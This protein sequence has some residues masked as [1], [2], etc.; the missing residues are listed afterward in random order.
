MSKEV[1]MGERLVIERICSGDELALKSLYQEHFPMILRFVL[2]NNGSSDEAKD[3]YQEAVII[4]YENIRK[5]QFELTCKIS[6]YLY[7]VCRRL[8]LKQL[9]LKS[10]N[11]S[12]MNDNDLFVEVDNDV[13][14]HDEKEQKIQL[15]RRCMDELG[16]PCKTILTDFFFVQ[17]TME[18]IANKMGYTNAANAKN[19]K[20]KCFNRFKKLVIVQ[21]R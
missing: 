13:D 4:F 14:D 8:W 19:Q 12:E 10:R 18:E 3:V 6:T 5:D 2:N 11:V 1:L 20:Y 17:L 21:R 9:N 16:E 7:S 15:L